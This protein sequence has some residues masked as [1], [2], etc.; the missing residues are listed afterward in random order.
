MKWGEIKHQT[1]KIKHHT[2]EPSLALFV[3][4]FMRPSD[5]PVTSVPGAAL[6]HQP[7]PTIRT[8]PA[9]KMSNAANPRNKALFD[10]LTP[11]D[12]MFDQKVGQFSGNVKVNAGNYAV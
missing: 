7:E 4:E 1:S 3:Q 8:V 10:I 11:F 12:P 2:W 9:I 6:W 5:I